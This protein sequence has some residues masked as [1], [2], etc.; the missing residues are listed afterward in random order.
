MDFTLTKQQTMIRTF[1]QAF[2]K[3]EVKP[4]AAII[5]EEERHPYETM[6]KMAKLGLMGI[7]IPKEYGGS[8]GDYFSYILIIEELAKACASTADIL[9]THISLCCAPLFIHGTE[10]QKRRWLPRLCNT[11]KS[12]ALEGNPPLCQARAIAGPSALWSIC[13]DSVNR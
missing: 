3:N 9:S 2:T 11:G 1:I 6:A 12:P 7:T 4:L 13:L 8:G 5:D 10:E